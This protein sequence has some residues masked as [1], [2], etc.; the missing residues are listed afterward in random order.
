MINFNL[1]QYIF[2]NL[3]TVIVMYVNLPNNTTPYVCAKNIDFLVTRLEEHSI[4]A[5][6]WFEMGFFLWVG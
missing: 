3:Y 1:I 2:A 5:V 4:I 6:E